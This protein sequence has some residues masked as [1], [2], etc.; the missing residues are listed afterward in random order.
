VSK[1]ASAPVASG[2][3]SP[4]GHA[5]AWR[6]VRGNAIESGSEHSHSRTS[7]PRAHAPSPASNPVSP[8]TTTRQP[9]PLR[10]YATLSWRMWNLV[11]LQTTHCASAWSTPGAS[12]VTVS[13]G[14]GRATPH[15]TRLFMASRIACHPTGPMSSTGSGLRRE[16][17]YRQP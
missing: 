3:R 1:S 13:G 6:Q 16:L 14:A 17:P 9:R 12:S 7:Q 4:R 5:L 15:R 2:A 11:R 10:E 8:V